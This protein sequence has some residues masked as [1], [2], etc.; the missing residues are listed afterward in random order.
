MP[1]TSQGLMYET[2]SH[3]P[4]LPFPKREGY[5]YFKLLKRLL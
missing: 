3:K 4:P 1:A 2:N 5:S